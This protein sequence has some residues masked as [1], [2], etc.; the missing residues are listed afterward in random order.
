[1]DIKK[2][3]ILHGEK[4]VILM[5]FILAVFIIVTKGVKGESIP[6]IQKKLDEIL[7]RANHVEPPPPITEN[8]AAEVVTKKIREFNQTWFG[9]GNPDTFLLPP[10]FWAPYACPPV[11]PQKQD[12]KIDPPIGV[13]RDQGNLPV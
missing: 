5:I 2:L 11:L 3:L 9:I 8:T 1:M 7:A 10:S 12:E 6:Q 13:H 4:L